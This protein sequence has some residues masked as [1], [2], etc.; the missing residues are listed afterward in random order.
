MS[1]E[2]RRALI[3]TCGQYRY[4][5]ERRWSPGPPLVWVMLNPSTAD[6]EKDDATIRRVRGFTKREGYGGFVVVNVWALRA[7]S[8]KDLHQRRQAYE[9]EN[10]EHVQREVCDRDVVV[11]WGVNVVNGPGLQR[12]CFALRAAKSVRCLGLTK[13]DQ[14]KHPLRLSRDTPLV[15]WRVGL[16]RRDLE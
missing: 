7:T 6:A 11:A 10:I 9:P 8:P 16:R 15:P 4:W 2:H 12:I 14:P 3:S 13:G 1:D 5:L